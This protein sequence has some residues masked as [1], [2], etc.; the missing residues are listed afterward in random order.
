MAVKG[1]AR[2]V[3]DTCGFQI[4]AVISEY[5]QMVDKHFNIDC[6]NSTGLIFKVVQ[7]PVETPIDDPA[8]VPPEDIPPVEHPP[9]PP[10]DPPPDPDPEPNPEESQP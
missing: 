8:D 2:F 10:E 1:V 4:N 3:C 5:Q 7:V 9:P 6:L